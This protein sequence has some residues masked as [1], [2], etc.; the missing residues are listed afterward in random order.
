M[1]WDLDN[2]YSTL[3]FYEKTSNLDIKQKDGS[4][5]VFIK[6]TNVLKFKNIDNN[7][8]SFGR[9]VQYGLFN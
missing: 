1:S 9:I 6:S 5:M 4:A 8:S 2:L 3:S 7:V